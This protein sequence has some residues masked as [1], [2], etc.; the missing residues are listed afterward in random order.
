M[1][2]KLLGAQ[3]THHIMATAIID[4]KNH[5]VIMV[6]Q[7]NQHLHMQSTYNLKNIISLEFAKQPILFFFND[8]YM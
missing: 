1:T 7:K 4:I 5:N 3:N 8:R 2:A 6:A